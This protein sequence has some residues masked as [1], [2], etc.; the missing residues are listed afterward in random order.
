VHSTGG[1]APGGPLS[2]DQLDGLYRSKDANR[3]IG[4]F[5]FLP[6]V[7]LLFFTVFFEGYFT[8]PI[9]IYGVT[10]LWIVWY[11]WG[12]IHLGYQKSMIT[13]FKHYFVVR[14]TR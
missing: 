11:F 2:A 13:R 5:I 1:G 6:C 7:S 10:S 8:D 12:F 14:N 3:V 4:F 9:T